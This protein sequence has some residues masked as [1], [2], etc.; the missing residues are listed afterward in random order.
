MAG[1]TGMP[2]REFKDALQVNWFSIDIIR[3]KVRK[4]TYCNSFATSLN[5][6][7]DNVEELV[8]CARVRWK[9]ENECFNILKNNG[10][11]LAR[12]L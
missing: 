3:N 9:I 6:D 5:T 10:H 12:Y 1:S 4:G 2:I 7:E 8:R 11:H